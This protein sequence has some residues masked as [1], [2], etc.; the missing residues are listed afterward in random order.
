MSSVSK[1]QI[2]RAKQ[3]DLLTYLQTYEPDSIFSSGND[4]YRLKEHDSFVIS[5]SKWHWFSKDIGG[6]TALDFLIHVR[7]LDF[8][9][10]VQA[11][12]DGY[13]VSTSHSQPVLPK[14]RKP[15]MLPKANRCG[16][17]AIAY[18]QSRGIDSEIILRCLNEGRFYESAK[19]HNCV[20]VGF[21]VEKAPRY[22]WLRGITSGFRQDVEGSDKRF[23]FVLPSCDLE[24]KTVTVFE[25][26]IDALSLA[27][28]RKME[29]Q[30]WNNV[31]Y[32]SLGG[33]SPLAILQ[34]LKDHHDIEQIFMHLDDDKAGL[35]AMSKIM[36]AIYS[37][38]ELHERKLA[39][40]F[41]PPSVGKDY[42]EYL[43]LRLAQ[44]ATLPPAARR[45]RR[46]AA[47]T[48]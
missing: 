12:S 33:T 22:A 31:S 10:A 38:V 4:E 41:E 44:C 15:F 2:T 45:S 1:E 46:Q 30:E 24:C 13:A 18:L 42:N 19:Y 8:V 36:E 6:K 34:Y 23:G 11:L 40:T 27:T 25:S 9:D 3:I 20:F 28:L 7:G 29:K 43:A 39:I 35:S 26:P 5:N 37:D 14:A 16:F 32:L 21:D 48:I 17:H 47:I